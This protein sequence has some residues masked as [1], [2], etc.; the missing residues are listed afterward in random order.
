MIIIQTDARSSGYGFRSALLAYWLYCSFY[1]SWLFFLLLCKATKKQGT[2]QAIGS[3]QIGVLPVR[4]YISF[5]RL[6]AFSTH[7][8]TQ[9]MCPWLVA[10]VIFWETA[11]VGVKSIAR[12][13]QNRTDTSHIGL[14]PSFVF[15]FFWGS[16]GCLVMIPLA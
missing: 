10:W 16:T 9:T 15:V 12:A 14:C 5:I 4:V 6:D 2:G 13:E 11:G 7:T 3:E 1:S 8:H